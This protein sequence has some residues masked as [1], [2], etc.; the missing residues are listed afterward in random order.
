[1]ESCSYISQGGRCGSKFNTKEVEFRHPEY[2][3]LSQL[4]YLCLSHF[5]QVFGQ[6]VAVKMSTKPLEMDKWLEL[7][8][9]N[10][11][12]RYRKN[13]ADVKKK[14]KD[15]IG[16]EHFDWETW[17]GTNRMTLEHLR[18]KLKTLRRNQCRFEWCLQKITNYK[19][20]YTIR[21]YPRNQLDYMNLNFCCLNHWE[22]YKKRIG[23]VG[24]KGSLDETKTKP[25]ST[26]DEFV[27]PKKEMVEI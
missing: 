9:K 17:I 12:V 3:D 6:S 4:L 20:I 22:V 8:V 13:Q 14:V 1:M 11:D 24:L 23:L 25:S 27:P 7:Q 16:D 18:L 19:Q 26:L 10:E 5:V 21:V 15:G 2:K